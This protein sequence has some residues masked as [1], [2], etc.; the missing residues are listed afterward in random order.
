MKTVEQQRTELVELEQ[1]TK[2]KLAQLGLVK[3]WLGLLDHSK[4]RYPEPDFTRFM[5]I[6]GVRFYPVQGYNQNKLYLVWY[7]VGDQ[8]EFHIPSL[9]EEQ[10]DSH[11]Q[12]TFE[13]FAQFLKNNQ[14]R[15]V[16]TKDV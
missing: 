14:E 13:E 11:D 7:V 4:I 16:K 12:V 8:V 15:Y 10:G 2:V 1:K 5:E 3:N 6:G 9:W